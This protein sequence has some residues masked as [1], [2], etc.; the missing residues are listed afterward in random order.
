MQQRF[1]NCYWSPRKYSAECA[2]R[3]CSKKYTAE[4]EIYTWGT[5]SKAVQSRP[6]TKGTAEK[7]AKKKEY[8]ICVEK[9]I[10]G[11]A[12]ARQL[13]FLYPACY[14]MHFRAFEKLERVHAKP[15][16]V[17]PKVV[18]FYGL[19]GSGKTRAAFEFAQQHYEDHEIYKYDKIAPGITEWWEGYLDQK[20]II[21]DELT[22]QLFNKE[23][24]QGLTDRWPTVVG[25]K[26]SSSNFQAELIIITSNL[27]PENWFPGEYFEP[28]RRRIDDCRRVEMVT[29]NGVPLMGTGYGVYDFIQDKS[30]MRDPDDKEYVRHQ[31][32][33][34]KM[35]G[36]TREETPELDAT[37][38]M[39]DII[40][41]DHDS[42]EFYERFSDCV[43]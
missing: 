25:M 15:R 35:R 33:E 4:G 8:Q 36:W 5:I 23:R 41:P 1:H 39:L 12:T 43:K 17:K 24:F 32:N 38:N 6:Q 27:K 26:G 20:C 9:L 14:G 29:R 19:A 21:L 11:E 40:V 7:A 30:Q 16:F 37:S 10:K 2:V 3:Y 42:Q 13:A 31:L 22:F 18:V 28:V 34:H